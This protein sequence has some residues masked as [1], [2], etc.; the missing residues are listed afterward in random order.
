MIPRR[1]FVTGAAATA[2]LAAGHRGI[3]SPAPSFT[4]PSIA[5]GTLNTADWRGRPVL[6][7]NTASLCGYTPQLAGLQALHEALGP[8]GLVVLA[9]PS[10]SFAQ[11]YSSAE[12]VKEFCT[13]QYGITLPMTD[14]VPVRGSRAHP[15]YRWMQQAHGFVPK[16]NFNKVL[17]DGTGR[18]VKTWGA[19]TKPQSNAIRAAVTPLLTDA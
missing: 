6:V 18:P 19:R 2:L 16:W 3:A 15:F 4:F 5:G 8:R 13:I 14:I 11:E 7:V 17:L 9:V 10:N 12:R 1:T